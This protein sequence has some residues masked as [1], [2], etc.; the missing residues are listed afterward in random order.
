MNLSHF[1]LRRTGPPPLHGADRKSHRIPFRSGKW[2]DPRTE[3]DWIAEGK[4]LLR[5]DAV[6]KET[7]A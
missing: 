6:G 2:D 7:A 5:I 4:S 1:E 3:I